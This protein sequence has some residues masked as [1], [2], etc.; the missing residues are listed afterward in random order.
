MFNF[1]K[2]SDFEKEVIQLLIKH[3]WDE[4]VLKNKTETDLL[5]NWAEIL[6]NNN[7]GKDRLN[8]HKLTKGEKAQLI[9]QINKLQTPLNLNKFINGKTISIKRDNPNDIEHY[10]KEIS[11]E[12][13]DRDQIAG[14]KSFYQIVEQPRF[15]TSNVL[16]SDRRGDLMLLING[17]PVIHIELKKSGIPVSQAIEQIRKYDSEG[18]FTGLF[19]LVQIFV[20]MTP[21]DMR[22]FAN[23]NGKFNPAFYF[24]W[25]DKNNEPYTSWIQI[26]EHLLSIPMAHKLIGFY[27]IPDDADGVL[28]VMR[29]YQYYAVEAINN[30]VEQAQWMKNDQL[31]G[32]I[33]HTTGSGKTMTSFKAAQLLSNSHK[34]DKVVFLMDRIELGAQSVTAYRGFADER[35]TIQETEDTQD[36]ISKLKSIYANDSLIVTSIQKMSNIHLEEGVNKKD[37]DAIAKNK[38]VFIIDECHRS[39]FGV[40]LSDI[41]RTFPTALYFGF[42]GTPIKSEN[43]K[44]MNTTNSIFGNELHRYS[45]ADGIRDG[46]VLAF[47]KRKEITFKDSDLRKV[48]ALQQCKASSI[49]EVLKDSKKCEIFYKFM[50]DVPMV[51]KEINGKFVKGIESYLNNSQYELNSN[52]EIDKQHPYQVAKDILNNWKITSVDSK[53]HA[54]FATSSIREAIQYYQLFKQIMEKEN[55]P[56]INIACLFDESIDNNQ[57]AIDK[58]KALIEMLQD[59]NKM[60]KKNFTISRYQS[61]KKDLQLRLAHKDPYT[62][63]AKKPNEQLNLLIVVDQMLTGFDSKWINTLYLDKLLHFENIV[64]AFSRTNR[65]FG[66]NEGKPYGIIKWYRYP[67]TME[68]NVYKAFNLYSDDKA[69]DIFVPKLKCNLKLLNSIFEK[70]SNLFKSNK[71]KNFEKLPDEQEEKKCFIKLFLEFN[72]HLEAAKLQGFSWLQSEYRIIGDNVEEIE[73]IEV[74]FNQVIYDS[75]LARYKELFSYTNREAF[76]DVAFDLDATIIEIDSSKFDSDYINSKFKKYIE[77]LQENSKD[78]N[79]VRNMMEQ[80]HKSFATLSQEEQAYAFEIIFEIQYGRLH[81]EKN[82]TFRDYLNEYQIKKKNDQIHKFAK[83]I[84]VDENKL[85]DLM[86]T[87]PSAANLNEFNQFNDLIATVDFKTASAY[88][89]QIYEEK[90]SNPWKKVKIEAAIRDFILKGGFDI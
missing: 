22:Y 64:Q 49:D 5:D 30:R 44:K 58:E 88:I 60:F 10:G 14:G 36:L 46:N 24:K 59:Y 83:K 65:V 54:L 71:I 11:L 47:D 42:T 45:I 19:S 43:Q 41:K 79:L 27:T 12:I 81:I 9:E 57:G 4:N 35:E 80:L 66:K 48:V 20:A 40:M 7:K 55:F 53:F 3:G 28:K 2:E 87:K 32:Y 18:V 33:W 34:V 70:I 67:H 50:N 13:Y 1:N 72:K 76:K 90:L 38:I 25:A 26:I 15:T 29:S 69:Y 77:S 86:K 68:Q 78:A 52:K 17:M 39:T 82:K 61:Y 23:P 62:L 51:S 31:G 63:L 56:K 75:L 8:G 16:T 21:N 89:D 85:R 84:G 74:K 73:I 37:I 6:Y